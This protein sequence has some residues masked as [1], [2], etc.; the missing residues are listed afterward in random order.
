M[1][2]YIRLTRIY[3]IYNNIMKIHNV[4][5]SI[6]SFLVYKRY[7]K[8]LDTNILDYENVFKSNIYKCLE[9]K[10]FTTYLNK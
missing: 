9:I 1:N 3:G 6:F 2:N 5:V 4:N 10:F 8:I 7:I